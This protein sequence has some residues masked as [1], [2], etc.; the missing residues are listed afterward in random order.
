MVMWRMESRL[1]RLALAIGS[2]VVLLAAASAE[3]QQLVYSNVTPC[4]IVDTRIVGGPIAA[5]TQRSFYVAGTTG[6]ET[7]GGNAGGCAVPEGATAAVLNFVAVN[8]AGPGNLRAW[9]FG[10]SVPNA[11]ILNYAAIPGLNIA[12][13]IVVAICDPNAITCTFDLQVQA[14]SSATQLVI[15]VLGFFS[16]GP[17]G[18]TGPTGPEGA[19]GPTGATGADGATGATG[20]TGPQGAT[21]ATGPTGPTGPQG[22]Q[23]IQ[24]IQG[25]TGATG[26]QGPTGAT[27]AQGA[28]GPT[29]ATGAAGA[30]G[31]TG[32]QGPTGATG[33]Q[34]AQGP[35][36]ATGAAG[37]AGATGA[38]GPTGAQGA[39]GPTGPTGAQGAQGPTGPTG[40]T[41]ATGPIGP[42]DSFL[43]QA[44]SVAYGTAP[45]TVVSV[46]VPPGNY[47]VVGDASFANAPSL[48]FALCTLGSGTKQFGQ[49]ATP[50]TYD[51]TIAS[52]VA[53]PA[54]GT[55]SYTCTFSSGSGLVLQAHLLAIRVGTIN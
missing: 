28:Q 3:A 48:Q 45:F 11:S 20:A 54:G 4:R 51:A 29:G 6:F 16:Q 21:G 8:A 34:G 18:P 13:G 46:V 42:S 55:I 27:G 22:L 17:T 14:D 38:T 32:A 40:P 24:G 36:G 43:G 25:P 2:V 52:Q 33:A 37:A 7:Q 15:D 53:M 26:A 5:G 12:N 41:G 30:Q 35:T 50:M 23:G 1:G 47:S 19:V 49:P 10:G 39:Q 31:A 9:P 44:G